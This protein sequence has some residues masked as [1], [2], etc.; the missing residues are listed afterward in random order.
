MIQNT[1]SSKFVTNKERD[2]YVADSESMFN[3]DTVNMY[4][5]SFLELEPIILLKGE[6]HSSSSTSDDILF[7]QYFLE[8]EYPKFRAGLV[9]WRDKMLNLET[10]LEI[11]LPFNQLISSSVIKLIEYCDIEAA[12]IQARYDLVMASSLDE[13]NIAPNF[14]INLVIKIPNFYV[15]SETLFSSTSWDRVVAEVNKCLL[16]VNAYYHPNNNYVSEFYLV[17][18][19]FP[20]S[21]SVPDLTSESPEDT[22]AEILI[23]DS[24][25]RVYNRSSRADETEVINRNYK[26]RLPSLRKINHNLPF[27]F[28]RML[29][30]NAFLKWSLKLDG[31][32]ELI[33]NPENELMLRF[34]SK[35]LQIGVEDTREVM[36]YTSP[37]LLSLVTAPPSEINTNSF[38]ANCNYSN[39]YR[40]HYLGNVIY[41]YYYLMMIYIGEY[42]E[43]DDNLIVDRVSSDEFIVRVINKLYL[44]TLNK[45]LYERDEPVNFN[46][47]DLHSWDDGITNTVKRDVREP[48][49]KTIRRSI[50]ID[51]LFRYYYLRY[52][53]EPITFTGTGPINTTRPSEVDLPF[54]TSYHGSAGADETT[55]T[56]NREVSFTV[57]DYKIAED[58]TSVTYL[59][60]IN[61]KYDV[62]QFY[63]Y[64][65]DFTG[66]HLSEG[67][68]IVVQSASIDE[69]VDYYLTST[70]TLA[71]IQTQTQLYR[72]VRTYTNESEDRIDQIG[73][74]VSPIPKNSSGGSPNADRIRR[75]FYTTGTIDLI[76]GSSYPTDEEVITAFNEND[77]TDINQKLLDNPPYLEGYTTSVEDYYTWI[78]LTLEPDMDAGPIDVVTNETVGPTTLEISS[79]L[80]SGFGNIRDATNQ[81]VNL[82]VI[83]AAEVY[84]REVYAV[85][86]RF[87]YLD[88]EDL[89]TYDTYELIEIPIHITE[90]KP[91]V[92]S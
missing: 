60:K 75:N 9:A 54:G 68:I 67:D 79:Y 65:L 14:F 17:E 35:D 33:S 38:R 4:P 46:F 39:Y 47:I 87:F 12:K 80:H 21:I 2:L 83:S 77:Y 44:D 57:L 37:T 42:S 88:E 66:I 19:V 36:F 49:G 61:T 31:T 72:C 25:Y 22:Q 64:T 16:T 73:T 28:E 5:P 82:S 8:E 92:I 85:Y 52:L 76:N 18:N 50:I 86:V 20:V 69:E 45:D 90:H 56:I 48:G 62:T 6:V 58:G 63:N 29:E 74:Q 55:F 24:Y 41:Q 11:D 34:I 15:N 30:I 32:D 71:G 7:L 13:D 84:D 3:L 10:N 40:E 23:T 51:D 53:K 59:Y 1:Y 27:T 78:R 70:I 91:D 26:P 43:L 89:T 81:L